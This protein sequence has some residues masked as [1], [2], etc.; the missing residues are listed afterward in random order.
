MEKLE[1]VNDTYVHCLVSIHADCHVGRHRNRTVVD[2]D[3]LQVSG[4]K[5]HGHGRNF[6]DSWHFRDPRFT[7]RQFTF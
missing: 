1:N 3:I 7:Q 5:G 2:G 4:A 6:R